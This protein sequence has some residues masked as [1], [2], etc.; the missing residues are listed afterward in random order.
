MNVTEADEE[1]ASK[2]LPL[3][4]TVTRAPRP[5]LS[6]VSS[7]SRFRPSC[8]PAYV[9]AA[10][11]AG[12]GVGAERR[13]QPAASSV[14]TTFR[15]SSDRG[16]EP[17]LTSVQSSVAV[18]WSACGPLPAGDLWYVPHEYSRPEISALNALDTRPSWPWTSLPAAM[19]DARDDLACWAGDGPDEQA[20]STA[21]ESAVRPRPATRP[22]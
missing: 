5:G 13:F 2:H 7:T 4:N 14:W 1:P 17:R 10:G 6:F 22:T 11:W 18:Y 21:Q 15:P 16:S 20:A 12:L 3:M 9:A 19:T 8:W